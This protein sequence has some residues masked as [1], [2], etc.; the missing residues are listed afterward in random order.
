MLV[1]QSYPT[2][3]DPMDRACWAPLSVEF[4]R[5]EHCSGYPFPS[6]GN[7]LN[8]GLNPILLYYR[9][10]LYH[11]SHQG[12]PIIREQGKEGRKKERTWKGGKEGERRK[13]FKDLDHAFVEASKSKTN[14]TSWQVR[15]S[16]ELYSSFESEGWKLGQN[17]YAQVWRQNSFFF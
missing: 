11:L 13:D 4:S 14:R 5:Q 7:L 10:I 8:Q 1:I 17:F 9:Q 6:P 15:D 16:G 3:C 12:I 2:L